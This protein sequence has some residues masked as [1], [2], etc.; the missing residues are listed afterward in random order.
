MLVREALRA[1]FA[2]AG[3]EDGSGHSDQ[4]DEY[5]ARCRTQGP[6]EWSIVGDSQN[7]QDVCH[8]C[9][10]SRFAGATAAGWHG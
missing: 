3:V 8:E 7:C 6:V 1:P 9:E 10:A 2:V 4:T 5:K